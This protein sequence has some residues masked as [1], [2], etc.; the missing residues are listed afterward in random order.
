[1]VI[2]NFYIPLYNPQKWLEIDYLNAR[3][4]IKETQENFNL[5]SEVNKTRF[6]LFKND[7]GISPILT[8]KKNGDVEV[9][10]EIFNS[11]WHYIPESERYFFPDGWSD[12]RFGEYIVER[13]R[14]LVF[15]PAGSR[16]DFRIYVGDDTGL[17]SIVP[18][19]DQ[20]VLF[21]KDDIGLYNLKNYYHITDN[22]WRRFT[23]NHGVIGPFFQSK[24][25]IYDLID[26]IN[27]NYKDCCVVS[28]DSMIIGGK[29]YMIKQSKKGNYYLADFPT[30]HRTLLKSYIRVFFPEKKF[31]GVFPEFETKDELLKFIDAIKNDRRFS[32]RKDRQSFK[33]RYVFQIWRSIVVSDQHHNRRMDT[34]TTS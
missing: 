21:P 6:A 34:S 13:I 16:D 10:N 30:E 4:S 29:P 23:D 8:I 20:W 3:Y 18:F 26:Y 14:Q 33:F 2:C 31:V 19:S 1:M 11:I 24:E 25:K 22:E 15:M 27:K 12:E 32:E 5:Y 17:M 28:D 9:G 7:Y